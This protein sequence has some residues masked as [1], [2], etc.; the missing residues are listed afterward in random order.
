MIVLGVPTTG[1]IS[2]KVVGCIQSLIMQR[3][4]VIP[5]YTEGSLVYDARA[6]IVNYALKQHADLLFL[7]SD[8]LFPIEGFDRLVAHDM[9]IV[10]GLYYGRHEGHS[11]PIAYKKIRPRTRFRGQV[12]EPITEIKPFMYVDGVGL[13]FC[14]IKYHVLEALTKIDKNP[15]EPFGALGEDLSFFVRCRKKGYKVLLDTTFELKHLGE[16]EYTF[17]DCPGVTQ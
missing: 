11:G 12:L 13:G 3:K 7:D 15:F 6:G 1:A 5:Y 14:L 4:D 16:K 10:S 2:V 8:I 17:R 9:D